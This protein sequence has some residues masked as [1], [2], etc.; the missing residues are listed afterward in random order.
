MAVERN[1][2]D[3]MIDLA[4]QLLLPEANFDAHFRDGQVTML[5]NDGAT[6]V[7]RIAVAHLFLKPLRHLDTLLTGQQQGRD[8]LENL[9]HT[10]LAVQH[11]DGHSTFANRQAYAL[12]TSWLNFAQQRFAAART[13]RRVKAW[14]HSFVTDLRA[15]LTHPLFIGAVNLSAALADDAQASAASASYVQYMVSNHIDALQATAVDALQLAANTD[16]ALPLLRAVAPAFEPSMGAVTH[17]VRLLQ[18]SRAQD[19]RHV[20][21]KLLNNLG[22]NV[23][24]DQ[25]TGT[26]SALQLFADAFLTVNRTTPGATASLVSPDYALIFTTLHDFLLDQ[27]NGFERLCTLV[28][29]RNAVR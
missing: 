23:S 21:P 6:K 25:H 14:S 8:F 22:K 16:A 1:G 27:D 4:R 19:V 15:A 2:E 20:T 5:Q 11:Q 13:E 12:S 3:V 28:E 7:K 24:F 26:Q 10:M 17:A 9:A 18:E 29:T